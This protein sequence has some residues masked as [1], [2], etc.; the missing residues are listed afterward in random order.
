[1]TAITAKEKVCREYQKLFEKQL[2]NT[3]YIISCI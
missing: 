1:M 3:N 2:I